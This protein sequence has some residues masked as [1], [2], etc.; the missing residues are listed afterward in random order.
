MR[1]SNRAHDG[2]PAQ[3]AH[4]M[5]AWCHCWDWGWGS[6]STRSGVGVEPQGRI[7]KD[8]LWK[9]TWFS[10]KIWGNWRWKLNNKFCKH[11]LWQWMNFVGIW[12]NGSRSSRRRSTTS[13]WR[14]W[15]PS[16]RTSS[17]NFFK[18]TKRWNACR[19]KQS[20]HWKPLQRRRE[21]SWCAETMPWHGRMR[22][23]RMPQVDATHWRF[24][25]WWRSL[26]KRNGELEE[27]RWPG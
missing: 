14:R 27:P 13:R 1:R 10:R 4:K 26:W 5:G 25:L 12:K 11:D 6:M 20:P 15:K 23:W 17:N 2:Q 21:E 24:E 7:K 19:W 9:R 18:E 22:S 8:T 3:G 16:T